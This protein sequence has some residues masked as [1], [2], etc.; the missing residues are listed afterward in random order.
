MA[1]ISFIKVES[2][3]TLHVKQSRVSSSWTSKKAALVCDRRSGVGHGLILLGPARTVLISSLTLIAPA[4]NGR[5][6]G[7]AELAHLPQ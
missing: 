1:K 5:G 7:S 4:S 2:S 6:M 3:A